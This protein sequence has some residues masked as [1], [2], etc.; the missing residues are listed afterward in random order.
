MKS[1]RD[2][3]AKAVK[4]ADQIESLAK[5]LAVLRLFG[6]DTTALSMQEVAELLGL[7]RAAARRFLVTL[8][9]LGYLE[10]SGRLFSL[11][12]EVL[13]L[14]YSYY[15]SRDLPSIVLPFLRRLVDQ[16]GEPCGLCVL[17]RGD[18]VYLGGLSGRKPFP[19]TV[20]AG[21]VLPA[22]PTA[23]GRVLLA[24]LSNA[25]LEA[26]LAELKPVAY[27][28]ATTVN[29]RELRLAIEKTHRLGYC[30]LLDELAMG[31]GGLA[32]PVLDGSG[33]VCAALYVGMQYGPN[34]KTMLGHYLPHMQHAAKEIH[35][36][37]RQTEGLPV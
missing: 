19:A 6:P 34:A 37:L 25:A 24:G 30:L 15:A 16:I 1:T 31:T 4:K 8:E 29:V 22:H 23:S 14:G 28:P 18:V 20:N 17:H 21:T 3:R 11:T 5:G 33:T 32:V 13:R 26:Y 36:I 35:E 10:R 7:S 9:S 27:T 2:G 12:P